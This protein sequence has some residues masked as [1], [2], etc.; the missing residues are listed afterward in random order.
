MSKLYDDRGRVSSFLMSH[1]Y[2]YRA[3]RAIY[4]AKDESERRGEEY[5]GDAHLL[6]SLIRADGMA[7][8]VLTA[9]GLSLEQVE[10]EINKYH[11]ERRQNG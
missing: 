3:L 8:H 4:T 5:V 2:T 6:L 9:L 7:K 10:E 1:G 11:K